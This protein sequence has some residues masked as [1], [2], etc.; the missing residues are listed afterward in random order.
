MRFDK[1]NMPREVPRFAAALDVA[2]FHGFFRGSAEVI[3]LLTL[4]DRGGNSDG[5]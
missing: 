2:T 4:T 5:Q 1:R 3:G